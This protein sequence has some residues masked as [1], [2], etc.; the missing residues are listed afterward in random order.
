MNRLMG[1]KAERD[2]CVTL[3]LDDRID[4]K[5]IV[6]VID[7]MHPE[8]SAEAVATQTEL[9]RLNG[10]RHTYFAGSYFRYGFHEDAVMSAT[11]VGQAF[12][13]EL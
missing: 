12:G 5:K 10:Q 2:Y 13:E 11:L 6:K 8:F 1:L 9:P 7:Y 4:P 3:N